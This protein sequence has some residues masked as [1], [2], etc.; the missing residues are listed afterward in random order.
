M[1]NKSKQ[2]R[3]KKPGETPLPYCP[4]LGE[5]P[6]KLSNT[7]VPFSKIQRYSLA[8][9]LKSIGGYNATNNTLSD[10]LRKLL[11]I[12]VDTFV[13]KHSSLYERTI[14]KSTLTSDQQKRIAYRANMH[15][16]LS[17]RH[18]SEEN[19]LLDWNKLIRI[20]TRDIN[21]LMMKYFG[22]GFQAN[23]RVPYFIIDVDDHDNPETE[24]PSPPT[25]SIQASLKFLNAIPLL[26]TKKALAFTS[27]SGCGLHIY[28]FFDKPQVAKTVGNHIKEI[29]HSYDIYINDNIEESLCRNIEVMPPDDNHFPPLPLGRNSTLCD[30]SGH[31]LQYGTPIECLRQL[32]EHKRSIIPI[33]IDDIKSTLHELREETDDRELS[34]SANIAIKT[35]TALEHSSLTAKKL[36][37]EGL[38]ARGTTGQRWQSYYILAEDCRTNG[39]TSKQAIVKISEWL[40]TKHNSQSQD[41]NRNKKKVLDDIKYPVNFVYKNKPAEV[42]PWKPR[43]QGYQNPKLT[44]TDAETIITRIIDKLSHRDIPKQVLRKNLTFASHLLAVLRTYG[45]PI[46]TH[47]SQYYSADIAIEL[48]RKMPN[49][50][51]ENYSKRSRFVTFNGLCT[52]TSQRQSNLPTEFRSQIPLTALNSIGEEELQPKDA[53]IT[54]LSQHE[55]QRSFFFDY[56]SWLRFRK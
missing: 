16:Y 42:K 28:Y 49:A 54:Y 11:Q 48:V 41:Y 39:L 34:I 47:T 9:A 3:R 22:L 30:T 50:S 2:R 37:E 35:A 53:I 20:F 7:T 1:N 14:D 55:E 33:S 15:T 6:F 24:T 27:G 31:P 10:E 4:C 51:N 19:R 5:F 18:Q 36:W 32:A 26:Q 43:P 38:P 29:L 13:F 17:R 12:Y 25:K 23:Q 46:I 8:A 21:P 45:T 40:N 52:V 56:Q 44:V